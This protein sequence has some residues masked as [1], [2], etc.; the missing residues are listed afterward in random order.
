MAMEVACGQCQ[1]RLLVEQTGVVVACPHCGAHLAIPG[2][3]AAANP[4][5]TPAPEPPAASL[6]TPAPQLSASPQLLESQF[7]SPSQWPSAA[8]DVPFPNFGIPSEPAPTVRIF[9][10]ARRFMVAWPPSRLLR[11]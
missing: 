2:E 9:V 8:A 4:T 6:P 3:T 10:N 11:I 7:T 5:P 1:G